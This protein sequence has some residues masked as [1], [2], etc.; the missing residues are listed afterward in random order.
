MSGRHCVIFIMTLCRHKKNDTMSDQHYFI[1][2][3]TQSHNKNDPPSVESSIQKIT[4]IMSKKSPT[5]CQPTLCQP[6]LIQ[7]A[8]FGILF[9][10]HLTQYT[11]YNDGVRITRRVGVNTV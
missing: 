3:P 11:K 4:D 8:V 5:L 1:F 6:T 7:G 10:L 2:L 9:T